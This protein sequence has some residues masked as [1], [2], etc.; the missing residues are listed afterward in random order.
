MQENNTS[1]F[2]FPKHSQK[3]NR[4]HTSVVFLYQINSRLVILRARW[5]STHQQKGVHGR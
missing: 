2:W 5:K 1:L 3:H 4:R